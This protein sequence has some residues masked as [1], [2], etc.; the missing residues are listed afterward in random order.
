MKRITLFAT[1]LETGAER[2]VAVTMA[3]RNSPRK[4][5]AG[6]RPNGQGQPQVPDCAA[7][8]S[9]AEKAVEQKLA[10]NDH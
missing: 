8:I 7:S 9:G 10:E 4:T 2:A 6:A 5:E 3:S 1:A